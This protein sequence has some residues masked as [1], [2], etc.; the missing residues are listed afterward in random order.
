MR[1]GSSQLVDEA[2]SFKASSQR[3]GDP[4]SANSRIPDCRP[5]P[6]RSLPDHKTGNHI[7]FPAEVSITVSPVYPSLIIPALK[8]MVDGYGGSFVF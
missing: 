4:A 7:N 3:S 6:C 2:V 5:L 8:T 1:S